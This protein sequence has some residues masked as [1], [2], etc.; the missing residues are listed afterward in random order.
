MGRSPPDLLARGT[1]MQYVLRSGPRYTSR[2]WWRNLQIVNTNV[3][4]S[5]HLCANGKAES[6]NNWQFNGSGCTLY[7]KT[8]MGEFLPYLTTC[9]L[10]RRE[11]LG[12]KNELVLSIWPRMLYYN[13][14]SVQNK[15]SREMG[16][17]YASYELGRKTLLRRFAALVFLTIYLTSMSVLRL[18]DLAAKAA[19]PY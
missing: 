18:R 15:I 1:D 2:V 12:P 6:Q 8:M 3:L 16:A 5:S 19:S 10:S 11:F 17:G 7:K 13:Q 14:C 4:R 9:Q